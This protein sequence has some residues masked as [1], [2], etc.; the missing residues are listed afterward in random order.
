MHSTKIKKSFRKIEK[1][2]TQK[3]G[4][5]T[6][7]KGKSK[8][9]DDSCL[10]NLENNQSGEKLRVDFQEREVQEQKYRNDK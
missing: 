2:D 7:E 9:K 3:S 6:E 5:T 10:A 4:N 8:F 1:Y